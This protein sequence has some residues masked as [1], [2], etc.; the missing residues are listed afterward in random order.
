MYYFRLINSVAI[1]LV[2]AIVAPVQAQPESATTSTAQAARKP[3]IILIVSD[4]MDY[5]DVLAKRKLAPTPHIDSIAKNGVNFTNAYV[6]SPVCGPSRVAILT[7][8]YQDRYG[9]ATNHGP[10][11]PDN[12]GLPT[13]VT[14]VSESLKK[15]GYTT[16]MVGKWHLGFEPGMTPNGQ[17]FDYFFGHLHGAH[18]YTP[19]VEKPGPILRNNE[20]VI[21]KKYLTRE[22]GDEAARFVTEH[23]ASPYFLYVPFNAVHSP[24]Q[25]PDE[26]IQK[27]AHHKNKQDQ[28]MAAMLHEMD[29]AVGQILNAVKEKGQEENTLIVFTNDNGGINGKAPEANGILRGGKGMLYEGGI[30]VPFFMQWKGQLPAGQTYDR[31]ISAMDLTPTFVAAAQT[32]SSVKYDGKNLLPYVQR[33]KEGEPHDALFWHFVD[34]QNSK[35][36][37]KGDWKA[38]QPAEGGPW[39]LYNLAADTGEA[40]NLAASNKDKLTELRQDW[41]NW[42]KEMLPPAWLDVRV[43]RARERAARESRPTTGSRDAKRPRARKRDRTAVN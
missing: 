2:G 24:F 28:L 34:Q 35:A 36:V 22:F 41:R 13:T 42:N 4:D 33:A 21:T 18:H 12:F 29:A 14:L 30:R 20:P 7:G 3:N 1:A 5:D 32:S 16:G 39:E 31:M 11:I 23:S 40:N 37:R 8:Q 17:G 9:Y 43:V 19:G 6:T 38:V 26:T 27:Y 15:A 10:E 25:A